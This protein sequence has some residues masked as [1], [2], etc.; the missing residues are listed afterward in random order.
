[1]LSA[2]PT[3]KYYFPV[4]DEIVGNAIA[5]YIA[6]AY[7]AIYPFM[8]KQK[9]NSYQ[10]YCVML[11]RDMYIQEDWRGPI[12][13]INV[14]GPYHQYGGFESHTST[15]FFIFTISKEEAYRFYLSMLEYKKYLL[16]QFDKGI[17]YDIDQEILPLVSA[18]NSKFAPF[19]FTIFS[20]QGDEKVPEK[21]E[22]NIGYISVVCFDLMFLD[23]LYIALGETHPVYYNPSSPN[24]GII[25]PYFS[26]SF[27]DKSGGERY[28]KEL[29]NKIN[30]FSIY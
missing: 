11:H 16:C 8:I 28:Y 19:L 12:L 21:D 4:S 10:I 24:R 5:Q 1:M 2:H 27:L 18:I 15:P 30:S 7:I 14:S 17:V 9:G 6:D 20:C 3:K 22:G 23:Y 13:K 29:A 26:I 25:L